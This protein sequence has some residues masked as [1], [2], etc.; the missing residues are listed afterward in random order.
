MPPMMTIAS[1][2]PGKRYRRRVG[3]REP[4]M[5]REQ[6]AGAS[7]QR[8]RDHVGDLLVA[9]GRI[10]DELR[11]LL[12]FANGHQHGAD[13]RAMKAL[14]RVHDAQAERRHQRVVDPRHSRGRRRTSVARV[15]PPSPLSPPVNAVQRNAIA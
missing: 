2:A 8:R 11:A 13:R 15:T 10:T 7:G 14:E 3:R 9:V 1:S 6:H 12:V 5:E 4:M